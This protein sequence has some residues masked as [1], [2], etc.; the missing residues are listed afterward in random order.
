MKRN[1]PKVVG[2]CVSECDLAF[3]AGLCGCPEAHVQERRLCPLRQ[4]RQRALA[5]RRR[6]RRDYR[7]SV[8]RRRSRGAAAVP[9]GGLYL[10]DERELWS[11]H[12][13]FAAAVGYDSE[14]VELTACFTNCGSG[15]LQRPIDT[16]SA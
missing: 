4:G 1:P 15:P 12:H 7:V 13:S 5:A 2:E 6:R 11:A 8:G 9:D 3:E 10:L 16:T 14:W